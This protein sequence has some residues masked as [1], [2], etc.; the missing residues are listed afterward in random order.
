MWKYLPE[1]AVSPPSRRSNYTRKF[2]HGGRELG[3]VIKLDLPRWSDVSGF[4]GRP[5]EIAQFI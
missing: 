2:T 1:T 5:E 4:P 3:D